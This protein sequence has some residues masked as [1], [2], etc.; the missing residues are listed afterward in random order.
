MIFGRPLCAWPQSCCSV[1][2][3]NFG[4]AWGWPLGP[5]S[6]YTR[7]YSFL[8]LL[9][10]PGGRPKPHDLS[11]DLSRD[12]CLLRSR[13]SLSRGGGLPSFNPRGDSRWNRSTPQ[14]CGWE[15]NLAWFAY[16]G[17]SPGNGSK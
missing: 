12:C 7:S 9:S 8:Y 14:F 6:K 13:A 15:S 4:A 2:D 16:N 11:Q 3:G 5:A 17:S 1:P 10:S